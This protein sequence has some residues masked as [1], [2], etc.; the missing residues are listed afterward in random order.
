MSSRHVE[1]VTVWPRADGS[2]DA[3]IKRMAA[4][5]AQELA[6]IQEELDFWGEPSAELFQDGALIGEL[7]AV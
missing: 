1:I 2:L 7:H 6:L 3:T 5:T 4:N